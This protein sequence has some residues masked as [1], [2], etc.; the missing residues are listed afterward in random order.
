[1]ADASSAGHHHEHAHGHAHDHSH[2]GKDLADF[3]RDYFDE[4]ADKYDEMPGAIELTTKVANAMLKKFKFDEDSTVVMDYACGTGLISRILAPHSKKI[5]GVD[6]SQG[7]VNRY[8]LRVSNQGIPP[9][10]MQ[11][12]RLELKGEEG[13]LDGTKFDVIVCSMAYHHFPDID[14]TTRILVNF[15]KPGGRLMVADLLK[16]ESG[17][18]LIPEKHQHVFERHGYAPEDLRTVFEKQGLT[19][20]EWEQ[21]AEFKMHGMDGKTLLAVATK[22]AVSAAL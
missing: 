10:E 6:I 9:E 5:V 8:N 13:E 22:P 17:S 21:V 18:M 2:G 1:M 7:M 3:N 11:A 14:D 16:N 15:L 19:N 12:V 4:N 20:F